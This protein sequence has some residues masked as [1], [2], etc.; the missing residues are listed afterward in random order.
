MNTANEK[1]LKEKHLIQLF[2]RFATY[3]GSNPYKTPAIL[4]MI[5]HLEH[6]LGTFFPK[7]GMI[8][9]PQSLY[10]LAKDIGVQFH[11]GEKVKEIL[12]E[13]K[14][15]IGIKRANNSFFASDIVVSNADIVPTY[16]YLMPTQQ[17]PEKV[18]QQE[19]SSSAFIFYWGINR[20]FE[21][22]DLHNIFFSENYLSLIHI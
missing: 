16:R 22:L 5:P 20:Q 6:N 12:V 2:N 14:K 10:Q 17:A 13:K 3:N 1:L 4:C 15:T 7:N 18:L 11:L 8:S 9:I 21:Q 19:R